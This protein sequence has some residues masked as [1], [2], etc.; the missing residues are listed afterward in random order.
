MEPINYSFPTSFPNKNL[1]QIETKTSQDRFLKDNN[2]PDVLFD[3]KSDKE[4]SVLIKKGEKIEN[5]NLIKKEIPKMAGIDTLFM[6]K[7]DQ[8][9]DEKLKQFKEKMNSLIEEGKQQVKFAGKI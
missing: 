1:K 5:G 3:T 9:N 7:I 4:M 6:K 2:A 8:K